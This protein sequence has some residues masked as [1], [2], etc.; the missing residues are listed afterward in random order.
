MN[1]IE[2]ADVEAKI[3]NGY[4]FDFAKY[5]NDGFEIFKKEWLMFSLYGLVSLIIVMLS[6][7]TIVGAFLFVIPA[8]LGFAVAAEKVENGQNLEFGD[9][10]G[11][12][13]NLA[14][15]AVLTLIIVGISIIIYSPFI[16]F[17][18]ILELGRDS[19]GAMIAASIFM[20]L[21]YFFLYMASFLLQSSVIFASY[22]I[23]YGNYSGYDAFVTSI[24]LFKKQPW[25]I[26]LFVFV[27]GI[28]S[29]V[30]YLLCII[31]IFAS[32]AAGALIQ[33]AMVKDIL[34][35]PEHSEIDHIGTQAYH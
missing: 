28:I 21:Y 17:F 6:V 29:C 13:K 12:F 20:V 27:V 32:L 24:K 7:I 33:Y 11:A 31:G 10:F 1:R 25:W 8:L 14:D 34:S 18:F 23:H 19:E 26:L 22:L 9:F 15:Y 30:G 4:N 2:R 35:N 3:Q 5:L 16:L